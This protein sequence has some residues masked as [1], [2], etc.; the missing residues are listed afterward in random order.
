MIVQ[1][2]RSGCVRA[3]LIGL[4]LMAM[5]GSPLRAAEPAPDYATSLRQVYGAYQAVLARREACAAA[6]SA[7]RAAYEKAYG[8]WQARHRSLISELDQ[9][10]AMMIRGVSKD[11]KDFAR[12]VGKYEGMVLRQRE[13]VK[14][15]LLRLPRAELDALC[16]A[17]PG[18]LASADSDL[19]AAYAEELAMVRKRPLTAR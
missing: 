2:L 8:A 4:A 12:N 6:D 13:E 19:E 16:K 5:P 14:Q 7:R 11:E 17:L 3:S 15:E 18:F 1:L 9:R 10:F